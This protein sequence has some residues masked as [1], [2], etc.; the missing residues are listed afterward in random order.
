MRI[1]SVEKDI[2]W[3]QINMRDYPTF[4]LDANKGKGT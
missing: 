4:H 3:M 1:I 2:I